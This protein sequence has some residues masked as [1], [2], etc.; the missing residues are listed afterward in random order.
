MGSEEYLISKALSNINT[1]ST[2][3][4]EAVLGHLEAGGRGEGGGGRGIGEGFGGGS[5]SASDNGCGGTGFGGG[6]GGEI[7]AVG[8]PSGAGLRNG[9]YF[10]EIQRLAEQRFEASLRNPDE[11]PQKTYMELARM[12]SGLRQDS[13]LSNLTGGPAGQGETAHKEEVTAE[14][15]ED[16]AFRWALRRLAATP[17]GDEAGSLAGRSCPRPRRRLPGA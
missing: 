7:V 11:D 9:G 1:G 6:E 17:A 8:Q 3:G 16:A 2:H 10:T 15:F 12:L 14:V 13:V 4:I 5:G